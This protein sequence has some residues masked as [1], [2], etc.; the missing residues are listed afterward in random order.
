MKKKE[1][2]N[3]EHPKWG[4]FCARLEGP[5]GCDFKEDE[6][7]KVTWKCAGKNDKSFAMDI[8]KTMPGINVDDSLAFFEGSGGMCDCEILFNVDL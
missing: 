8:L 3:P 7:G 2:M 4:E 1:I 5:E 6:K